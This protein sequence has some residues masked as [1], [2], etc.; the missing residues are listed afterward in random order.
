MIDCLY[1]CVG[2]QE[3]TLF[4]VCFECYQLYRPAQVVYMLVTA[5]LVRWHFSVSHYV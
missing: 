2:T 5:L 1:D 4:F 3:W